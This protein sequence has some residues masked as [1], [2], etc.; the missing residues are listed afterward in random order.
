MARGIDVDPERVACCLARLYR[1]LRRAERQYLGLDRFDIGDCQIEV[2]LLRPLT[3]RPRRRGEIIGQL[4]RQAQPF[5]HEH[6]PV[7]LGESDLAADDTSVELSKRPRVGAVEYDGAHVGEWH[8]QQS[9]T[10]RSP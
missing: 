9:S 8:G 2:K 3:R 7:I 4:E 6:N 10:G 1:V 5:D